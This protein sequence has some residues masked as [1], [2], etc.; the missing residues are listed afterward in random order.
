MLKETIIL[1]VK[2]IV[3]EEIKKYARPKDVGKYKFGNVTLADIGIC[4]GITLLIDE[5]IQEL[6]L[7]ICIL[8]HDTLTKFESDINLYLDR[9]FTVQYKPAGTANKRKR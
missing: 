9:E 7:D 4:N 1:R 6:H 8:P 5:K 2:N 3:L